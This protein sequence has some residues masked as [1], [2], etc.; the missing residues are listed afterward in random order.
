[1]KI[2]VIFAFLFALSASVT[3]Y[4]AAYDVKSGLLLFKIN[5]P[6]A[7]EQTEE[8]LVVTY[9]ELVR[10]SH[11]ETLGKW[12]DATQKTCDSVDVTAMGDLKMTSSLNAEKLEVHVY[13]T[14]VTYI[15]KEL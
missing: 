1:M 3:T 12:M 7:E 8:Y 5:L 13:T 11:S 15:C 10:Q 6:P 2:R 4:A 14:N 9:P